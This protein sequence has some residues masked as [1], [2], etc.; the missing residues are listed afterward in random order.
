MQFLQPQKVIRHFDIIEGMRVAELH[1]GSGFFTP[2][3]LDRVGDYG[4]IHS[5]PHTDES[6][7]DIPDLLDRVLAVN[8]PYASNPHRL[9]AKAYRFMKP[10]GKMIVID[11]KGGV[12]PEDQ[13]VHLAGLAGFL[14]EKRF[15]AG[16][17]HFGLVFKKV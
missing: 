13:V 6:D 4:H 2:H 3:L 1:P 10:Q 5:M 8:I 14:R 17:H 9:F 11:L 16:D 12:L 7:P 15:N